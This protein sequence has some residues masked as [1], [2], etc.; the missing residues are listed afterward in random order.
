MRCSLYESPHLLLL[1]GYSQQHVS[2][3]L[4]GPRRWEGRAGGSW[5]GAPAPLLLTDHVSGGLGGRRNGLWESTPLG[6][7]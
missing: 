7:P 4:L 6:P 1:Q 3:P 2:A 5:L